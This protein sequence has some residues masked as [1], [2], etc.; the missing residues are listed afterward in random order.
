MLLTKT[1]G[2]QIR[3]VNLKQLAKDQIETLQEELYKNRLLVFK[4]QSLTEKE[5]VEF[6]NLFAHPVPYLQDNYHHPE[7]PLIFVS[8]NVK[9]DGKKMGVARTGGY[10]HSDTS[11]ENDP[12]VFTML[13]PK[14]IPSNPRS[15][16]F[17]D[18]SEVY[19]ELPVHL[20]KELENATFIHSGRNKYKVR[21]EDVGL[22]ISEIMAM[23][24]QVQ[25]PVEHPAVI[26]HPFTGEKIL[27][28]SSGFTIGIKDRST[29]ES[30]DILKE[31]FAFSEGGEFTREIFWA[32]GDLIVWDN[33]FL[34]HKS[35]RKRSEV[36]DIYQ[37]A[38]DEEGTMMFRITCKDNLPLTQ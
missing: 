35:G 34:I 23:I 32:M 9:V 3:G 18:M 7:Y 10:W 24:Q 38:S 26:K 13:M 28:A 14:V 21:N 1:I 16:L 17:I 36:D 6:A 4:D 30:D 5:Y 27:Y 19:L 25:P 37:V 22:D 12:K 29:D 31:L 8:S 2:K 20:K 33:R 11:F 15:T